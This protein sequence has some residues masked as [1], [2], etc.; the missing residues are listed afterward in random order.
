MAHLITGYAGEEHIGSKDQGSFNAAFFG[1]GQ[2]VMEIGKELEATITSNNN[3][4]ISDGDLL[5]NGRHIRIET[6]MYEDVLIETGTAGTNRN[7]LIVMRYEKDASTGIEVAKLE[8][9]KGTESEGTAVDSAINVNNILE[10][11]TVSQMPLYRVRVQGVVLQAVEP[12]F[13]KIPTYA[14]LAE[15]YKQE[16]VESC[17]THLDSLNILDSLDAVDMNMED[18]QLAGAKAVKE[19][20]Q[21]LAKAGTVRYDAVTDNVEILDADGSWN[22]WKLGGLLNSYV[23]N[24]GEENTKYGGVTVLNTCS[25][26]SW[27]ITRKD[28]TSIYLKAAGTYGTTSPSRTAVVR[29]TSMVDITEFKYLCVNFTMKGTTT[30][31]YGISS[32]IG[33]STS[34]TSMT[35]NLCTVTTGNSDGITKSY[36]KTIDITNFEGYYY[37]MIMMS[38]VW[39]GEIVINSIELKLN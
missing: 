23:Y 30:N 17:Q 2:Y 3:I 10:G 27:V 32:E 7:D 14:R 29:S 12:M 20:R 37:P 18:N 24:L 13:K 33:L 34:Q 4:R 16:F 6:D 22:I 11:A 1:T 8:V 19:L 39:L 38:T 26:P 35:D 28:A 5:M 25:T 36:V 9:V 31:T 15:Q 21:E